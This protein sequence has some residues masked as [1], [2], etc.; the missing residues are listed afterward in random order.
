MSFILDALRKSEQERSKGQVPNL[1]TAPVIVPP[2]RTRLWPYL[3]M[4]VLLLGAG[5]L[6]GWYWMGSRQPA[7]LPE[8]TVAVEPPSGRT[9]QPRSVPVP[10]VTP[11]VPASPA[12][13]APT[14][15]RSAPSQP[16]GVTVSR[17]EPTP[18][19]ALT[20]TPSTV[21][22]SSATNLPAGEP[23][24]IPR[25]EQNL[26]QQAQ[27]P[28]PTQAA[29]NAGTTKGPKHPSATADDVVLD[30][31]S[32][33]PGIRSR[34]PVLNLQLHFYTEQPDRRLIRLNGANLRQGDKA[35]G[36]LTVEKITVDGV[37]FS[38]EGGHFRL[39]TGRP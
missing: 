39:R 11:A 36:G 1:Q 5:V 16:S 10:S 13:P 25:P 18:P 4:G 6:F 9:A 20:A 35:E 33:P 14:P 22:P 31:K 19:V 30:I 15:A 24:P 26:L 28:V 23:V 32:L 3:L 17:T 12:T 29:P 2:S 21:P 27:A 7:P 38:F 8:L 34:L 37:I